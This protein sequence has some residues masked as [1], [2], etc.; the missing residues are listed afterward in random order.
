MAEGA[1]QTAGVRPGHPPTIPGPAPGITHT[2]LEEVPKV[3]GA[4]SEGLAQGHID[5]QLGIVIVAAQL[6][7]LARCVLDHKGSVAVEP[8]SATLRVKEGHQRPEE[9]LPQRR[10]QRLIQAQLM[11]QYLGGGFQ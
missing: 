1:C 6:S 4:P 3:Q 5:G 9:A 2:H 11:K 7:V 10:H 8:A